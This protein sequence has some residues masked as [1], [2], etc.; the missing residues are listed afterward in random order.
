M[1]VLWWSGTDP[2]ASSR[3]PCTADILTDA[4]REFHS[5]P[6]IPEWNHNSTDCESI[7]LTQRYSCAMG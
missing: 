5:L 1:L 6:N 4:A 2:A 7:L 3:S